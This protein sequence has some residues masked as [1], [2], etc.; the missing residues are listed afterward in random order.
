MLRYQ[1]AAIMLKGF[2]LTPETRRLY[3][4]IG[5]RMRGHQNR[6]SDSYISKMR[7]TLTQWREYRDGAKTDPWSVLELGTGWMHF[8]GLFLAAFEDTESI[9]FDVWDNRQLPGLRA[10]F[11]SVRNWA[12]N[13]PDLSEP[14]R[15]RALSFLTAILEARDFETLYVAARARYVVS[16]TGSL[17]VVPDGSHDLVFSIDVL[18]HIQLCDIDAALRGQFRVLKPGGIAIHQIGVDDHLEHYDPSVSRKQYLKYGE[19]EWSLRFENS[20]QYFNRISCD[21]FQHRFAAAGFEI[22]S[23]E[24][25]NSPEELD[26]L[27]IARQ[28]EDQ[29][30]KSLCATRAYVVARKP[31]LF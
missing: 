1:L 29:S 6:F 22:I 26:G 4:A 11:E 3:R 23:F 25:E 8:G 2:S 9:F 30:L 31:V 18:E 27:H 10:S 13:A 15:T 20:V 14:E 12:V 17:E 28:C 7:K 19:L 24:T 5:N 16:S 21:S